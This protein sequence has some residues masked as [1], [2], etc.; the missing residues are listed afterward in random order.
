MSQR[1]VS[2]YNSLSAAESDGATETGRIPPWVPASATNLNETHSV[3]TVQSLLAFNFDPADR[4]RLT[5]TC[6]P[7][8]ADEIQFPALE[9][10]WWP[11]DLRDATGATNAGFAIYDCANEMG[12]LAID[13]GASQA[14]FWI[15]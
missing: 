4:E 12:Y 2:F 1:S 9:A 6:E 14:Y 8:T 10:A 5:P 15:P 7:I 3:D 11:P 13:E